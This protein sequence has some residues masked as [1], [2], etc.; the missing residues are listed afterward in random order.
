MAIE[1]FTQVKISHQVR[2]DYSGPN[3]TNA[4]WAWAGEQ[5]GLPGQTYSG[6]RW[7]WNTIDTF[8]FRDEADAVLFALK[9]TK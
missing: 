1:D 2:H 3:G 9:W 6:F 5:F 8:Y 4:C 7:Q